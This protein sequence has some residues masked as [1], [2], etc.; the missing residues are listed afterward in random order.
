[1]KYFVL[2]YNRRPGVAKI[3]R[4][5]SSAHRRDALRYRFQ[6]EAARR[7]ETDIEIVVLGAETEEDLRTTHARYFTTAVDLLERTRHAVPA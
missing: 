7:D 2:V 1:M 3:E 5:F 6:L 4:V